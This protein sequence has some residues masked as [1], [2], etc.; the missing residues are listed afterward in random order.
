MKTQKEILELS[1]WR[2]GER[3]LEARMLEDDLF[4]GEE[5]EQTG[6][7]HFIEGCPQKG[8]KWFHKAMLSMRDEMVIVEVV[9][10]AF[11]TRQGAGL[12]V[13]VYRQENL[14]E[15]YHPLGFRPLIAFLYEYKRIKDE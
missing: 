12:R 9:G 14:P 7:F 3:D 1:D 4:E 13:V 6:T 8:E 10:T 15:R 11:R 2:L 5:M